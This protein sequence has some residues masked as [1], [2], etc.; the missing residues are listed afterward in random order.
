MLEAFLQSIQDN[1]Q[2]DSLYLILADFLEERDDPRGEL[3]R[4]Q[5]ALRQP[6]QVSDRRKKVCRLRWTQE[7]RIRQLLAAG[8]QPC[9]P[10]LPNS[11]DMTLVLI[12]PRAFLMC[13]PQREP[14]RRHQE[15]PP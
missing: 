6:G 11:I 10:T 7:E 9:L 8:V 3:V 13:I 5:Y 1:P 4:L 2:D 12:A 14:H 15:G